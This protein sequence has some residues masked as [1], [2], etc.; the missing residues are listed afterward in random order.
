MHPCLSCFLG[1][2]RARRRTSL[3]R[4]AQVG[5]AILQRHFNSA[6]RWALCKMIARGESSDLRSVFTAGL[7]LGDVE[8]L[9]GEPATRCARSMVWDEEVQ[10]CNCKSCCARLR[11][12]RALRHSVRPLRLRSVASW[13]PLMRAVAPFLERRS[14]VTCFAVLVSAAWQGRA[15]PISSGLP[16]RA[17]QWPLET[18]LSLDLPCRLTRS[19]ALP[20]PRA[21]R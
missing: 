18:R 5:A 17:R 15:S 10:A 9:G 7:L 1:S 11:A 4:C 14:R 6:V 3:P 16:Y 21:Q 2:I 20:S 13:T 8:L 12:E 19:A